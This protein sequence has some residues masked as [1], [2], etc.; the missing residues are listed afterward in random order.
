VRLRF[1]LSIL[2]T[3]TLM[4]AFEWPKIKQKKEKV[5]FA[6][7]TAIGCLLAVFLVWHPNLPNPDQFVETIYRPLGKLLE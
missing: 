6:I 7:L 4:T 3:V 1:L 5:A 2:V